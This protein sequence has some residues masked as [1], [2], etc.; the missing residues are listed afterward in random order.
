MPSFAYGIAILCQCSA[1]AIDLPDNLVQ[2]AEGNLSPP[3]AFVNG[4]DGAQSWA[5]TED[6]HGTGLN[7]L[8]ARGGL[9]A[10]P[11]TM[12]LT[13]LSP[14]T[15]R[16]GVVLVAY[17]PSGTDPEAGKARVQAK[18]T[19]GE[20]SELVSG[21]AKYLGQHHSSAG[22]D[23]D[24]YL[25][26]LGTTEIKDSKLEVTFINDGQE[27]Y[28]AG[29]ICRPSKGAL[30][31]RTQQQWPKEDVPEMVAD[32]AF[33]GI[34]REGPPGDHACQWRRYS[35]GVYPVALRNS[36]AKKLESSNPA[37][38]AISVIG[39]AVSRSFSAACWMRSLLI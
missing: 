25:A 15:Y 2:P 7:T 33:R 21:D 9:T 30:S 28:I 14:D 18:L 17:R 23:Y 32:G 27:A 29:I 38:K 16:V 11:I 13:D 35:V 6:M 39:L 37:A 5:L 34:Y 10:E 31:L 22:Y 36:L 8:Y 24:L 3:E 12:T 20:E 26:D 4:G 1:F 19:G